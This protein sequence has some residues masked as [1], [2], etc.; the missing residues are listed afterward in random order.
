MMDTDGLSA[1]ASA[2]AEL[3]EALNSLLCDIEPVRRE[4]PLFR[5]PAPNRGGGRPS[6]AEASGALAE[7]AP[8]PE[9]VTLPT[10]LLHPFIRKLADVG[11]LRRAHT[12]EREH[13]RRKAVFVWLED[14]LRYLDAPLGGPAEPISGYRELSS[15]EIVAAMRYRD[16]E[17]LAARVYCWEHFHGRV[18]LVMR[19]AEKI[20]GGRGAE[21]VLRMMP[22]RGEC[23]LPEP[24]SG[25]DGLSTAPHARIKLRSALCG[26]ERDTLER[27]LSYEQGTRRRKTMLEA[28]EVA[29]RRAPIGATGPAQERARSLTV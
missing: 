13:L 19:A 24:F 22:D 12:F 14:Q 23:A 28:I 5:P 6:R 21:L 4:A 16:S 17:E 29:L 26:C 7:I 11:L 2:S 1:L 10:N 27:A 3:A 18:R 25:F 15:E 8:F 9:L 20:C